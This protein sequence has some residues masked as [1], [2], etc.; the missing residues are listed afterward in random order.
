MT[1]EVAKDSTVAIGSKSASLVLA[2]DNRKYVLRPLDPTKSIS[3]ARTLLIESKRFTSKDNS[4]KAA[5]RLRRTLLLFG[6]RQQIGLG[7]TVEYLP[8]TVLRFKMPY[9]PERDTLDVRKTLKDLSSKI[10]IV[11]EKHAL[12]LEL[13]NAA[14]FEASK[15]ARFITFVVAVESLS[16]REDRSKE[17]REYIERCLKLVNNSSLPNDAKQ[18]LAASLGN[19]KKDSIGITCRKL[20]SKHLGTKNYQG[21]TAKDFFQECYNMRSDLVHE[22]KLKTKSLLFDSFIINL[23][24]MVSDLLVAVTENV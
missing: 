12:A 1:I 7:I 6:V 17:A 20:V 9:E 3:Q 5:E 14:H 24:R 2:A 22:G 11:S 18:S 13:Y 16:S 4:A 23:D 19:L 10:N 21:K 15:R 8:S